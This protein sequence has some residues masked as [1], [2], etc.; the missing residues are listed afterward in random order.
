MTK[1]I[2]YDAAIRAL[3]AAS[4][5]DEAKTIRN[6]AIAVQAYARQAGDSALI[7]PATT[8]RVEAEAR[9][10]EILKEMAKAGTRDNGKGNRNKVLKSQ[11]VTP[12]LSDLKITKMQSSRWQKLAG[13][14]AES[15]EAWER[16]L[17]RIIR[18]AVASCLGEKSAYSELRAEANVERVKQRGER[19]KKLATKL[20]DLP[21]KKYG[22]ILADP[23][24][25]FET[26][27]P[28]GKTMTS[29]E[30]H[31]PT[32]SLDAIKARDVPSIAAKDCVLFLWATVPML[33]QALEVMHAWG[34]PKYVSQVVWIKNKAGTGYWFRNKHE[35]LLVATR[36]DVPAPAMGTQWESVV[37]ADVARHSEKPDVFYELIESYFPNLPKIELNQRKRRDGWDGWG[38]E[39]D[40][41][42]AA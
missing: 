40:D 42:V 34:F 2:K 13:M 3:A 15:I 29:A 17:E 21:N 37:E 26:Y 4:T 33:P 10:G 38:L 23:E 32:S 41:E 8:I 11:A 35:I 24:W 12:K 20:R 19:E 28:K 27:S 6:K 39:A 14:K 7:A 1:L 25:Q 30:N 16:R 22:V 9:A 18:V 5:V 31:Y 36:G